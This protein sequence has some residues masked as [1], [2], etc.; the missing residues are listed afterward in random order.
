MSL[1]ARARVLLLALLS[2][3]AL[4]ACSTM[5]DASAKPASA[6]VVLSCTRMP[7]REPKLL[8]LSCRSSGALM[9]ETNW[10]SWGPTRAVG[11]GSFGLTPCTQI[12]KVAS[13]DFFSGATVV[14]Q[15]PRPSA[16][17]KEAFS[18]AV[19]TASV[20]GRTRTYRF[21]LPTA[22]H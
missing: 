8:I 13:M 20:S 11:V 18:E 22:G 3:L 19:V 7:L 16:N 10:I 5:S 17:G 21:A 15:D 12:C 1:M 9:A 2:G 6:T 4:A 14:L